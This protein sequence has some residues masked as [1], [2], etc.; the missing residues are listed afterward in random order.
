[1]AMASLTA[2]V[3]YRGT[4]LSGMCERG[5]RVGERTT[6]NL[7]RTS[8]G[9]RRSAR[10]LTF[11]S[12]VC[13]RQLSTDFGNEDFRHGNGRSGTRGRRPIRH[14]VGGYSFDSPALVSDECCHFISIDFEKADGRAPK[15]AA[16][17]VLPGR[18]SCLR[19]TVRRVQVNVFAEVGVAVSLTG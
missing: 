3:S 8:V 7:T 15:F 10:W 1:M 2:A 14:T 18:R 5:S 13:V 19:S 11:L 16:S 9:A 6:D 4:S 17:G 12:A